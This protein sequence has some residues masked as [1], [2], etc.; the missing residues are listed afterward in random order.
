MVLR[1]SFS[2]KSQGFKSEDLESQAVGNF[3]FM[4]LS[5]PKW[6]WSNCFTQRA[7][8]GEAPSCINTVVVSHRPAWRAGIM[9]CCNNEAY[10]W[11]V[12][13][14]VALPIVRNKCTTSI[15]VIS[16][17]FPT[18]WP[19]RSPDLYPCGYWLRGNVKSRV[20][21]DSVTSLSHLTNM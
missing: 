15:S 21:R 20:Y 10:R 3:R 2:E 8:C 12:T 13:M 9:N 7:I 17:H 4:I 5:S 19:P 11:P 14:H 16:V 18:F 6:R 1:Y